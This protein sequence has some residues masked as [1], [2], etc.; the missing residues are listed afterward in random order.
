M[1]NLENFEEKL[2]KFKKVSR[3][4]LSEYFK[5]E[6]IESKDNFKNMKRLK[7]LCRIK[8]HMR[9]KLEKLGL[10]GKVSIDIDDNKIR[11]KAKNLSNKEKI[12]KIFE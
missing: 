1:D 12:K 7:K 9:K 10:K 6:N 3:E 8:W 5:N 11:I 4:V 2:S